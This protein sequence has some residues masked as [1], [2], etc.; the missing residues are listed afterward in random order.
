MGKPKICIGENKEA[1]QLRGSREADQR[2]CFR[3]A[4]VFATR[5][6]QLLFHLNPKFQASGSFLCLYRPVCVGPVWKPHCWFSHETAYLFKTVLGLFFFF[7][8]EPTSVHSLKCYMYLSV[9]LSGLWTVVSRITVWLGHPL[10][11]SH[12]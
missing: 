7:T 3:S 6:V 12:T 4:F 2:L 9:G 1:D 8:L 5:I 10:L 11:N